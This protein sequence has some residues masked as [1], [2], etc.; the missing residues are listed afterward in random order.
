ME[1]AFWSVVIS[2]TFHGDMHLMMDN[3]KEICDMSPLLRDLAQ[4]TIMNGG[5]LRSDILETCERS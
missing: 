2:C 5:N 1:E 3:W 4:I